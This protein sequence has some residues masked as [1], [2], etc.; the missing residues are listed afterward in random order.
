VT[1]KIEC[2]GFRGYGQEI[3]TVV[4]IAVPLVDAYIYDTYE[5]LFVDV[6]WCALHFSMLFMGSIFVMALRSVTKYR[7]S[8]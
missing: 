6:M 2:I 7:N 1:A 4:F 5:Y 3:S 8:P